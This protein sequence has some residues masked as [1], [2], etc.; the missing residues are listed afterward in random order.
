MK[1]KDI[2]HKNFTW[3]NSDFIHR[4]ENYLASNINLILLKNPET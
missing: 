2:L 3:G 1:I 4:E